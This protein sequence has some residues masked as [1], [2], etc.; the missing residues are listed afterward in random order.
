ME[1]TKFMVGDKVHLNENADKLGL[2]KFVGSEVIIIQIDDNTACVKF[3][4]GININI[5]PG[6]NSKLD[7]P[8]ECLSHRKD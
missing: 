4:S 8:I 6:F 3:I 7:L 2:A 1:N 5:I